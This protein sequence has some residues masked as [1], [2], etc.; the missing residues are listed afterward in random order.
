MSYANIT[1]LPVLKYAAI[2]QAKFA[3]AMEA[4]GKKAITTF[5]AD[6][7]IAE[8]YGPDAVRET[9]GRVLQ[10]WGANVTYWTE[11]VIALNWK[12]WDWYEK[13][14]ELAALYN[15]LWEQADQHAADTFTGEDSEYF[16]NMT[17]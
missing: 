9:Y 17:D 16:Y 12:I 11:F 6:L 2:E 14:D 13:N 8:F 4:T 15:T 5:Y 7:S 3:A 10:Q 1:E